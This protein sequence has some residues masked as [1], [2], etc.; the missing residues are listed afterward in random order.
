VKIAPA[1][2]AARDRWRA[3]ASPSPSA[4][5]RRLGALDQSGHA[6]W[7]NESASQH[8]CRAERLIW[9]SFEAAHHPT[10]Q[11]PESPFG[12][13][14]DFSRIWKTQ[15]PASRAT[16]ITGLSPHP[17]QRAT[18]P[19]VC[20]P[21]GERALTRRTILPSLPVAR[22]GLVGQT[23]EGQLRR[24]PAVTGVTAG[25]RPRS[26]SS[27]SLPGEPPPGDRVSETRPVAEPVHLC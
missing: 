17:P 19:G 1:I 27:P 23:T 14:S 15:L 7:R 3:A 5:D 20:R 9:R 13:A 21:H 11:R 18:L 8:R 26:A 2:T 24:G 12:R 4:P 22:P 10:K 16:D 6:R 25:C